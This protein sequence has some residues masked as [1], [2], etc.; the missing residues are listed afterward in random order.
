MTFATTLAVST[1][2]L[3]AATCQCDSCST[4]STTAP[5]AAASTVEAAEQASPSRFG[6]HVLGPARSE[7]DLKGGFAL[8]EYW[9]ESCP[10]CLRVIPHLNEIAEDHTNLPVLAIQI[11]ESSDQHAVDV[12][13]NNGG[14]EAIS[15]FNAP[16]DDNA[17]LEGVA[18]ES[19]PH[20]VLLAPDGSIAWQGSPFDLDHDKLHELLGE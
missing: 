12:W 11:W 15:V 1:L 16:N 14:S 6:S 20:T 8:I 19:I 18:F 9:G 10:P 17:I 2:S 4:S 3:L 5:A 7:E 13:K